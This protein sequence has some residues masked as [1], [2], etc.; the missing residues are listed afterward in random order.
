MS[1]LNLTTKQSVHNITTTQS[2]WR[3]CTSYQHYNGSNQTLFFKH[4]SQ[5]TKQSVHNITTT[6]SKWRMCTSYQHYNGSNQTLFFK[7]ISQLFHRT[8]KKACTAKEGNIS[9]IT[10]LLYF[11]T[12]YRKIQHLSESIAL[13]SSITT[14]GK[15]TKISNIIFYTIF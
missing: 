4:I 5:S 1:G 10:I 6:Q 12:E 3:M 11:H 15:E 9:C 14:K 7:H 2:K 8:H 13:Y